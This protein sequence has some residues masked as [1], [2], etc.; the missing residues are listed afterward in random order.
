[1]TLKPSGS[2]LPGLFS[3]L[4]AERLGL[5]ESF[6]A[7]VHDDFRDVR[8]DTYRR[9]LVA[10]E[11]E[12]RVD[13]RWVPGRRGDVVMV[14]GLVQ[15]PSAILGGFGGR[16]GGS[17]SDFRPV[18]ATNAFWYEALFRSDGADAIRGHPRW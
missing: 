5:L 12:R 1:M 17:G 14:R 10:F 11:V 6:F 13:V 4:L 9:D 18:S 15:V 16:S 2:E 3:T 8:I 7:T